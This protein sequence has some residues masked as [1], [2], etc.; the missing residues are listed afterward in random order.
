[1]TL[2][3]TKII[4]TTINVILITKNLQE[5]IYPCLNEKITFLIS[6]LFYQ[7]ILCSI[8]SFQGFNIEIFLTPWSTLP[9]LEKTFEKNIFPK[10]LIFDKF[11]KVCATEIF[12]FVEFW[13][14]HSCEKTFF[15]N[16]L[17]FLKVIGTFGV[18]MRHLIL[19]NF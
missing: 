3:Q 1:M 12:D 18:F 2:F 16:F 17:Y 19:Q 8:F 13:K 7:N 10:Y 5:N 11:V 14:F 4:Q 6:R 15:F 9:Y